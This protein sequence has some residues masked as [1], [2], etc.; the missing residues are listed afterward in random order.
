M[1]ELAIFAVGLVA[2]SLAGLFVGIT[3]REMRG[4]RSANAGEPLEE[5]APGAVVQDRHRNKGES[6]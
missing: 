2:F 6:T 3:V 1:L 4:L 5:W